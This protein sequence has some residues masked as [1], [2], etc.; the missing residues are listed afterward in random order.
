[1]RFVPHLLSL[2]L[3]VLGTTVS[4][5]T[6]VFSPQLTVFN[7]L[8]STAGSNGLALTTGDTPSLFLIRS[9]GTWS[10][11]WWQWSMGT[12]NKLRLGFSSVPQLTF[13]N[14]ALGVGSDLP[15]QRLEVG[16]LSNPA[17]NIHDFGT[18]ELTFGI[19]ESLGFAQFNTNSGGFRFVTAQDGIS[20]PGGGNEVA[21]FMASGDVG[22]GTTSPTAKLDVAG[23]VRV[24]GDLVLG[25]NPGGGNK[26][27]L[28]STSDHHFI[29]GN[30][31]WTEFVSHPN[32]GWKF[33]SNGGADS[34]KECFRIAA[35]TG[36]VGIGTTNPTHKLA[37]NGTIKAKEVIV[38]TTGWSDYV[39]A[40]DYALTPLAEVEAHIKE[41]KHLPGI[42]SAVQVAEQ[43]VSVGEMQARLLAKVEE[44]TLYII[45]IKK[46]N[47][48]L[49]QRLEVL[50]NK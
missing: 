40:E 16:A 14:G 41:H 48:S 8:N 31:W 12:D 49:R 47:T 6:G 36:N 26:L 38:E 13:Q 22:I 35:G 17:I 45:D 24:G 39:F 46:E 28:T 37:V 19:N 44:L 11:T 30:G 4:A 20:F 25:G 34:Y 3:I 42:P 43:G 23:N 2:Q 50:E 10:D 32:E 33:I 7:N 1:M 5:Q 15:R 18:A 27:L 9:V 21:R 29:R